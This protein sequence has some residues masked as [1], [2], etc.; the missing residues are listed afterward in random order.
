M[1]KL[2]IEELRK[3]RQASK[4][5]ISLRE[6]KYRGK[7]IVHLGTCGIASG[8]RDIMS[9][10]LEEFGKR[11]ISDIMFGS[12]GCAGQCAREPMITVEL[13]NAAPVKYADLT[14]DKARKIL[15]EHILGGNIVEEYAIG[16]GSE[17]EG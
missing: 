13:D 9:T 8:A 16:I 4:K 1:A 3:L 12:S 11:G 10:F 17:R 5:D 7:L 2:N 14:P 15:D 6:G